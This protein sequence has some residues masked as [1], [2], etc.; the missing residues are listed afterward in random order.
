MCPDQGIVL[1]LDWLDSVVGTSAL[2]NK[3]VGQPWQLRVR[4]GRKG[5]LNGDGIQ[6]GVSRNGQKYKRFRLPGLLGR[7][8][9]YSRRFF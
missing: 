2:C 7:R 9:F 3:D 8:L 1:Q 4:V 5:E 6:T